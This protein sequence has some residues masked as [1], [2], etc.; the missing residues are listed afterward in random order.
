MKKATNN[1][2]WQVGEKTEV[3]RHLL[4]RYLPGVSIGSNKTVKETDDEETQK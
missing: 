2:G 4:K 3:G 1:C